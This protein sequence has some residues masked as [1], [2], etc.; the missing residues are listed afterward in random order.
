MC[1]TCGSVYVQFILRECGGIEF[2]TCTLGD[3]FDKS[4]EG[5]GLRLELGAKSCSTTALLCPSTLAAL[6]TTM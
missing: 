6:T 3:A 4:V 2:C 5:D 1:G